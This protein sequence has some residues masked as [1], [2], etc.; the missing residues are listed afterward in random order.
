MPDPE[1]SRRRRS[2]PSLRLAHRGDLEALAR[3]EVL[4]FRHPWSCSQLEACFEAP[5]RIVVAEEATG[6]IT[7]YLVIQRARSEA[8]LLRIAVAP[9]VR[10]GG[11]A[12]T[13]L[14]AELGSLA[15][16]GVGELFLEVRERNRPA[17]LFYRRHG[18]ET[19]GRRVDY[20]GPGEHALTLRLVV[21][22]SKEPMVP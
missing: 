13:L 15:A 17:L 2:R 21:A 8:D 10:R 19:V 16:A 6:A 5:R 4:C 14:R 11:L 7:G 9:E 22:S 18:F 3:L 12:G 20:Y 1:A